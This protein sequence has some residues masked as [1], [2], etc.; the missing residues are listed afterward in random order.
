F[1]A[2]PVGE[3]DLAISLNSFEH[4]HNP[5]QNLAE[6]A[7]SVC[8]GGKILI[9]FGPPWFAPY[10]SHMHFFT[11]LPWVNLL[12]PE[13]AVF[14]VRRLYREDDATTYLPGIN[15]MSIR[16]FEA[17]IRNSGLIV[18]RL[19]YHTIWRLPVLQRIP[20]LRELF[21]NHVACVLKK[22]NVDG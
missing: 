1:A 15:K 12:F 13:R 21:I 22:P 14:R 16:R 4:F 18:E 6:L 11:R 8:P 2:E 10:G 19:R 17:I 9:S 3:F 7:R 20:I 5:E